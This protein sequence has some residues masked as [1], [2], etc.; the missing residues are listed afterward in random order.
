MT[1]WHANKNVKVVGFGDHLTGV[2]TGFG[3]SNGEPVAM[4]KLDSPKWT[5]DYMLY[6][7]LIV[8]HVTNLEEIDAFIH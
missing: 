1:D 4:V 3:T 7:S 6:I 2:I 8:V 5:E